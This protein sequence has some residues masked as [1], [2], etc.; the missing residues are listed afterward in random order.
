MT[1][2]GSDGRQAIRT[3]AEH[4]HEELVTGIDRIH[5]LSEQLVT[6]PVDQRATGARKVLH[7]FDEDFR[8]HMAWEDSWL[9]PELDARAHTPW[10]TRVV[11]F[12]HQQIATQAARLHAQYAYGTT[13]YPQ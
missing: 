4:E 13:H 10:A 1:A 8:P 3:F 5:E 6:L 12:D 11:R 2:T 7:W 9:F